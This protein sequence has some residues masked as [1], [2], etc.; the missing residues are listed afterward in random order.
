V[1]RELIWMRPESAGVGRPAAH[2]RAEITAAAIAVAERE[3]FAAVTMRRV[4]AELGTGAASLYRYVDNRG[5]LVDLMVDAV[6]R[7]L[8]LRPTGAGW[9]ADLVEVG[10]AG[11]RLAAR[12]RWFAAALAEHPA[13]TGPGVARLTEFCLA[14]LA[15]HP[16][17]A[18]RKMEAIGVLGGMVRQYADA[19]A[20]QPLPEVLAAHASYLAHVAHDGDHPHLAA[21][22]AEA[23]PATGPEDPEQMLARILGMVLDG[24]LGP[25]R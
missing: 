5:D 16:A 25:G 17:P 21:A 19:V 23:G 9:R 7:E 12:H 4:A 3:G 18:A 20:R 11:L 2:S 6:Y 13:A 24:V 15:G 8:D 1:P 10:R 22:L 14:A